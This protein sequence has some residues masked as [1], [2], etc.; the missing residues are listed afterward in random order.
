MLTR[1]LPDILFYIPKNNYA[2]GINTM[3]I[4]TTAA[5]RFKA[6]YL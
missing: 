4:R 6:L 1:A 3:H 2:Y 5:N